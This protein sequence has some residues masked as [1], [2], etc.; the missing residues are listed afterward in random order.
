MKFNTKPDKS[1]V[2]PG[3]QPTP[4]DPPA[5]P[6]FPPDPIPLVIP[7]GGI[8]LLAAASGTGK[9]ALLATLTKALRAGEP[10]FGHQVQAPP[11]LVFLSI[12]RSWHQSTGIWF[13][14]ADYQPDGIY[15]LQ[16]DRSFPKSKLRKR[17][18]RTGIFKE[19]LAKLG[20][21]P[22]GTV[23]IV[24]TITPF[25]GGNINDY[26]SCMVACSELR[27]IC[28]DYG[29]T[30]IGTSHSSKQKADTRQ[31]YLRLQDRI[32]GTMAQFG[33]TDTQMY[34]ASPEE[35]GEEDYVFLWHPHLAPAETF[36]L[37]RGKDGLFE[38]ATGAQLLEP[39]ALQSFTDPTSIAVLDQIPTDEAGITTR[40]LLG[41]L[42]G[43]NLSRPTLFRLL[44]RLRE[45]GQVL[46]L[47]H[48][49]WRR[50]VPPGVQ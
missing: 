34:L 35:V 14:R 23:I 39:T 24:D 15:A 27:E 16:D 19:C 36:K 9:T 7:G 8:S 4:T 32:S 46:Q 2:P 41:H 11:K 42:V 25:L 22:Y 20:H 49:V 10:I 43:P 3:D 6:Q 5:A 1:Q 13:Q 30:M 33:Y 44:E 37:K 21:L 29:L 18:N 38:M 26:D 47:R 45:T 12:D 48:G 50:P 40:D 31:R 28:L 17:E